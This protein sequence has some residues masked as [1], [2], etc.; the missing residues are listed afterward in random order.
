MNDM[1]SVLPLKEL[2]LSAPSKVP[3]GTNFRGVYR[4]GV[5][6]QNLALGYTCTCMRIYEI[7]YMSSGDDDDPDSKS[8]PSSLDMHKTASW[9]YHCQTN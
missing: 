7:S 5:H 4:G 1:Y 9:G 2:G 6:P 8:L 3:W